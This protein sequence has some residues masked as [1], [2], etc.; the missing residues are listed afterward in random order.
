[1]L[2]WVPL[3]CFLLFI[4]HWGYLLY[5]FIA[6]IVFV[7]YRK[8][9][10]KIINENSSLI[11]N[12]QLLKKSEEMYS[13]LIDCLPVPAIIHSSGI[14]YYVNKETLNVLGADDREQVLR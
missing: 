6:T 11:M 3:V 4:P 12:L 14:I 7:Y 10:N 5:G 2:I 8:K 9:Y 1:M 13:K